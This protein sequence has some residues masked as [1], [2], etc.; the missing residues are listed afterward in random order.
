MRSVINTL[1]SACGFQQPR[2][3]YY[4][5]QPVYQEP[6][7]VYYQPQPVYQEPQPVYQQPQPVYQEP[8]P[9]YQQPQP[10]LVGPVADP[11]LVLPKCQA[12]SVDYDEWSGCSVTCGEG[13]SFRSLQCKDVSGTVVSMMECSNRK[14]NAQNLSLTDS[15]PCTATKPGSSAGST[16]SI[17]CD[18]FG[19]KS[20]P[21]GACSVSCGTGTRNRAVWCENLVTGDRQNISSGLDNPVNV[22]DTLCAGQAPQV[23][24]CQAQQLCMTYAY[25]S[26][27]W[28]TRDDD[29]CYGDN[30]KWTRKV[31]CVN[32][33]GVEVDPKFCV[34]TQQQT[35]KI[36]KYADAQDL[37]DCPKCD[38]VPP[39]ILS[40]PA[41][42]ATTLTLVNSDLATFRADN[43]AAAERIAGDWAIKQNFNDCKISST[44]L[45]DGSVQVRL[46][47][48]DGKVTTLT[49]RKPSP[50][51][52]RRQE[53]TTTSLDADSP[54]GV[55]IDIQGEGYTPED[56]ENLADTIGDIND[57]SDGIY[58][59]GGFEVNSASPLPPK[60]PTS[61]P[62]TRDPT[63]APVP[64]SAPGDATLHRAMHACTASHFLRPAPAYAVSS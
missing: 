63:S 45:D 61:A 7:P 62:T 25:A 31:R 9:V 51:P 6:Q 19:F 42:S 29:P 13:I 15:R 58:F 5:P 23:E 3:V 32:A 54:A 18:S 34:G 27:A 12:F 1:T 38:S 28:C 30:V 33:E 64:T 56:S 26:S 11:T 49:F 43:Y 4:Q 20:G 48:R 52:S 14:V 21:W 59:L 57:N 35:E 16:I 60:G 53:A 36:C 44:G 17:P 40:T 41:Q 50:Q 8:Q 10:A 2:P 22:E 46:A 55:I 24:V 37:C 39:P 47:C